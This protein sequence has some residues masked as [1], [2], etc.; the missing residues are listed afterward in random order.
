MFDLAEKH[1]LRQIKRLQP[2]AIDPDL[3]EQILNIELP[4]YSNFTR[5]YDFITCCNRADNLPVL[6]EYAKNPNHPARTHALTA[7]CNYNSPEAISMMLERLQANPGGAP[8]VLI[9]RLTEL[10]IRE[11]IP[12]LEQSLDLIQHPYRRKRIKAALE[13]FKEPS[14][15]ATS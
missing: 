8:G 4:Y 2:E 1:R 12:L 9:D 10:N 13:R 6:Y 14:E 7:I 3:L 15:T 5:D 11:V